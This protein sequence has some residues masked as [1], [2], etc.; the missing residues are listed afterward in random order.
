[1]NCPNCETQTSRT[2]KFCRSCGANL[3]AITK[4]LAEPAIA[5]TP[6]KTS[7]GSGNWKRM[8]PVWGFIIMFLG[9]MLSVTSS[10]LKLDKVVVMSGA[11]TTLLGMFLISF[12]AVFALARLPKRASPPKQFSPSQTDNALPPKNETHYVPSITERTTNLLPH[13]ITTPQQRK[14]GELNA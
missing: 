2:Q 4:P 14:S 9:L 12:P 10:M 1:M 3:Q 7:V 11:L 5:H 13:P 6:E 8:L